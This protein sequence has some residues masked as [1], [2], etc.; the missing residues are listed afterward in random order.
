MRCC[1]PFF[2]QLVHSNLRLYVRLRFSSIIPTSLI[3]ASLPSV[4]AIYSYETVYFYARG[5]LFYGSL[6]SSEH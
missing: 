2:N 5:V 1:V 3:V 6:C 4:Y